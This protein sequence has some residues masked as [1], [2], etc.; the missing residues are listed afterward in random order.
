M[1]TASISIFIIFIAILQKR[2]S[3]RVIDIV[4]AKQAMDKA[5]NR[6]VHNRGIALPET[7]EK[8]KERSEIN[9]QSLLNLNGISINELLTEVQQ[10]LEKVLQ[11]ESP[12]LQFCY[13]HHTR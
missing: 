4:K 2:I 7:K 12:G 11:S 10:S 5:F 9:T 1:L 6:I 3:N 13:I 8:E